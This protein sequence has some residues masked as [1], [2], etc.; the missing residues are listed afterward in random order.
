MTNIKTTSA[1]LNIQSYKNALHKN[2]E[3]KTHSFNNKPESDRDKIK[4]N[5]SPSTINLS[6]IK[7]FAENSPDIRFEK[8]NSLKEQISQGNYKIDPDIIADN[9]IG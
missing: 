6:T 2:T 5:I 3:K 1:D 4:V 9:I 7:S 8:I